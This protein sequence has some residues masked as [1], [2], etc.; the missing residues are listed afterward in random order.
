[1]N[2]VLGE[3]RLISGFENNVVGMKRGETKTFKIDSE[4]AYGA[5]NPAAVIKVPRDSFP[6][7]FEFIK[8]RPVMGSNQMG[9]PLRAVMTEYDDKEATLDCNHPLAGEDLTFEVE[10]VE[11]SSD[12]ED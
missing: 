12:S 10:L 5:P 4:N 9:Q 3:G 11:I 1:M 2:I 8:G 7:N 6:E